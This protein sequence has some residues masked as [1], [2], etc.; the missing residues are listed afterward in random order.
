M[1][2]ITI[3]RTHLRLRS[4]MARI[5]ICLEQ[6]LNKSEWRVRGADLGIP[7]FGDGGCM[8]L[9]SI[10]REIE[11]VLFPR[12]ELDAWE[13]TL[14]WHLFRHTHLEGRVSVVV[15]LSGLSSKTSISTTKLRETLRSM[16]SKGCL[17]IDDRNRQGHSITVRLPAEIPGLVVEALEIVF[18]LE[19]VDF[20]KK[21][22]YLQLLLE[23]QQRQCLYCLRVLTA[24]AAALDHLVP[25]SQGGDNSYRNVVVA[26]DAC[27]SQKQA[28]VAED[29]LRLLYRRGVLSQ[30]ELSERLKTASQ[31]SAGRLPP[32]VGANVEPDAAVDGVA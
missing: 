11:D 4:V 7:A 21:R 6:W 2:P 22:Q 20:Y 23:R 13:R 15:G 28:L 3:A 32:R 19:S 27:N 16:A 31:I 14:Y 17:A 12:L 10:A 24:E 9:N 18:D 8:N 5:A 30:E 26:C 29:Y 1:S 25:Q